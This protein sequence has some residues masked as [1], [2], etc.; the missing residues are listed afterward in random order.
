MKKTFL[1]ITAFITCI[2]LSA[3]GTVPVKAVKA[4][5]CPASKY[6]PLSAEFSS[7]SSVT[8][9]IT[10]ITTITSTTVTTAVPMVDEFT[11]VMRAATLDYYNG[12]FGGA[13]DKYITLI[14]NIGS[15]TALANLATVYKDTGFYSD[16]VRNYEAALKVK[17]DP[18]WR[19]SLGYCRFYMKDFDGAKVDLENVFNTLEAQTEHDADTLKIKMLAAFGLGLVYHERKEDIYSAEMYKKVL[20]YDIRLAQAHFLL[21]DYYYAAGELDN[22]LTCYQNVIKYDSSFYKANLKIAEIFT[23]KEKYAEAFENYK[24]VSY[25]EPYNKEVQQK[26]K[27]LG[28]KAAE[29]I[30]KAEASKEKTRKETK[31]LKVSYIKEDKGI[32]VLKVVIVSGVEFVRFKCAGKYSIYY[33]GRV[34]RKAEP[35]EDLQITR[36]G[37]SIYIKN[38]QDIKPTEVWIKRDTALYFVPELK[39]ATFTIFDVT[40]D[41][42]Y[43]WA[44]NKDRSYRGVLKIVAE[45]RGFRL[46]NEVNL[47]EYLYSVVPSEIGSRANIEAL[48][49]QAVVARSYIYKKIEMNGGN[50]DFHLCADVHCQA[51]TGVSS[52]QL[53]TTKAVDLTRGEVA[54]NHSGTVP[55]YFFSTCG[56]R[57][58]DVWDVWGWEKCENLCGVGDYEEADQ[59]ECYKDWPLTPENLDRWIKLSPVAYCADDEVYRWFRMADPEETKA[60]KI[61]KRDLNGYVRES[62]LGNK[63]FLLDRSRS[64]LSGLRSS[65]YKVEKNMIFGCGWGHGVGMCQEGA[66][67]MAAR[68]KSYIEIVTHYYSNCSVKKVY[69]G[70]DPQITAETEKAK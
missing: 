30:K 27:E 24:K 34:V 22:A 52:E 62:Q 32:P 63:K 47:E 16:A 29:Y 60:F 44:N 61:I 17:D 9:T 13:I 12:N 40:M 51:Y 31:C 6:E 58:S 54:Y 7:T 3:C 67:R 37:A 25:I 68:K 41:R 57:T 14:K 10:T 23:K 39:D 20:E 59:K 11:K 38:K 19:L 70:I 56:G 55:T 36:E 35:E 46:V 53:S 43:F 69:S 18:F 4:E 65:F 48:K 45:D 33:D 28:A 8:E 26:I 42:G 21:A 15:E 64:A 66:M 5:T 1:F 49:A 2:I 50:T